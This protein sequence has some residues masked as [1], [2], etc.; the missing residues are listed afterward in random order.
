MSEIA[1]FSIPSGF[2][3]VK[4]SKG[5]FSSNANEEEQDELLLFRIPPGFDPASLEGV[6]LDWPPKDAVTSLLCKSTISGKTNRSLGANNSEKKGLQFQIHWDLPNDEKDSQNVPEMASLYAIVP[7][8]KEKKF[9]GMPTLRE[10]LASKR[11]LAINFT[12]R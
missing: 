3:E 10:R 9:I 1:H 7:N 5:L 12:M 11:K 6:E 8:L 2:T 4:P